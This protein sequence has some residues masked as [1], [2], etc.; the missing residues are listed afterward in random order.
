MIDLL[1]GLTLEAEALLL[2]IRDPIIRFLSVLLK[3]L[4]GVDEEESFLLE[5]VEAVGEGGEVVLEL[6]PEFVGEGA[7]EVRG[8]EE[9]GVQFG[10]EL[11][12][13]V[14]GLG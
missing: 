9:P 7:E 6:D 2:E 4:V 14:V 5:Y 13:V 10:D 11:R 8:L 3:I 1:G 12:Y